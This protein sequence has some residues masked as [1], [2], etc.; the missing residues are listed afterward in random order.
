MKRLIRSG[1]NLRWL[2]AFISLVVAS[3]AMAEALVYR[4]KFEFAVPEPMLD[5]MIELAPRESWNFYPQFTRQVHT[6]N[7]GAQDFIAIALGADGGYGAQIRYRLNH[8]A[9][10]G[11][12]EL[13]SWYWCV[14][15]DAT[16]EKVFELFNP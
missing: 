10:G 9:N 12:A 8:A 2:I 5:K 7:D 14:I 1:G 6:D 16:G 13:G 11:D 15:T 4:G 3:A